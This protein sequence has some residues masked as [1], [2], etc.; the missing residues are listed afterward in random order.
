M[1]QGNIYDT[2]GTRDDEIRDSIRAIQRERS[3]KLTMVILATIVGICALLLTAY[4][5][6]AT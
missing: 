2:H 6:F 4:L 3:T 5:G 1:A